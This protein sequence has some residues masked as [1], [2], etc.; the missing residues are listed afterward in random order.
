MGEVVENIT[1]R[2]AGDV[3]NFQRG[4]IKEMEIRQ[5]IVK[6]VADTGA[7]TIVLTEGTARKLGLSMKDRDAVTVAG[8]GKKVCF[9]AEPVEIRWKDRYIT[10]EPLVLPGEKNDLLG[11]LPLE[12]MD[13]MVDPVR[14]R[15]TGAHG[16]EWARYVR[17]AGGRRRKR[18]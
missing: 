12:G 16:D 2:N 8:G 17:L 5:A 15:L 3:I 11:A 4:R 13:L 18:R 9:V 6:M 7:W 10:M 1:L 14:R